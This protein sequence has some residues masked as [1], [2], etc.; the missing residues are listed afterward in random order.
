MVHFLGNENGWLISQHA[1]YDGLR[2]EVWFQKRVKSI[3]LKRESII[4]EFFVFSLI[5]GLRESKMMFNRQSR[6]VWILDGTK[7]F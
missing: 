7:Y 6:P 3:K 1:F 2:Y 5:M 4:W